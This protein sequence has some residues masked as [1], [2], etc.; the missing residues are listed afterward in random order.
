MKRKKPSRHHW[1][2][3]SV[4]A[5]ILILGILAF[6]LQRSTTLR[7]AAGEAVRQQITE[8]KQLALSE[9]EAKIKSAAKGGEKTVFIACPKD[10]SPNEQHWQVPAGWKL[11]NWFAVEAVCLSQGAT[12]RVGC[13]YA[14]GTKEFERADQLAIYKDFTEV[15]TCFPGYADNVPGCHCNTKK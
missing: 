11:A 13:Y 12:Q 5:V 14:Y 4:F 7:A 9:E 10:L 1:L 2:V 6:I 15:G 3:V 8:T